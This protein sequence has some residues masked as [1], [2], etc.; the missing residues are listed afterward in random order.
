MRRGNLTSAHDIAVMSRELIR[1]EAIK[2]YNDQLDG[3][4]RGGLFQLANTNRLNA[5]TAAPTGLKTGSTSVA[6]YCLAATAAAR[7]HGAHRRGHGGAH[8]RRAL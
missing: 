4:L 1:H 2:R 8:Q 6:K 7:R 5:P 3:H